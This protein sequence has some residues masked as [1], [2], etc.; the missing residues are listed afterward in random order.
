[1]VSL[2]GAI[3]TTLQKLITI[4][5]SLPIP[6][7]STGDTMDNTDSTD[8]TTPDSSTT[9]SNS[10]PFPIV[11]DT[12]IQTK[13]TAELLKQHLF[14]YTPLANIQ[15]NLPVI[16]QAL[17]NRN[18]LDSETVAY[19]I[20]TI[21]VENAKFC[22]IDEVPSK[23]STKNGQE[24][25]DF[26]AYEFRKDLGNTEPLDGQKFHGRSIFQLTGR[27]NYTFY[28]N[29]LNLGGGLINNPESANEVH[30]SAVIF[31]DY[32]EDRLDRIKEAIASGDYEKMRKIVNAAGL[33]WEDFK[34]AYDKVLQLLS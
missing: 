10:D 1:M 28:D 3:F 6:A 15:A 12:D 30:I 11:A 9:V 22:P 24:P 31:V 21:Y 32:L 18:M 7:S 26:S 20:G 25:Y 17:K 34:T 8:I 16:L 29:K 19:A 33:H 2:F 13:L 14:L 4:V 27:Y 23:W 5:P